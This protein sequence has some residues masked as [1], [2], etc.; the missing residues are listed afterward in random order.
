MQDTNINTNT[1]AATTPAPLLDVGTKVFVCDR[2][3]GNWCSGFEVAEVLPDGYQ[4]RRL[5]DRRVFP[6]VFAF[7][8]VRRERRTNPERATNGSPLDRRQFP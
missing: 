4:L 6:D 8:D 2:Y 7:D 1:V 3:L 5:T